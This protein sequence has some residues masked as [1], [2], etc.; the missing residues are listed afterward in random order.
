VLAQI[1]SAAVQGIEAFPVG[2]E[3]DANFGQTNIVVIVN[4][5][6]N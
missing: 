4:N 3:V 2:V 1:N 6:P 5:A